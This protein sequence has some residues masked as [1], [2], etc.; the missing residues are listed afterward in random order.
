[1][2]PLNYLGKLLWVKIRWLKKGHSPCEKSLLMTNHVTAGYIITD[3]ERLRKPMELITE[4]F[5]KCMGVVKSAYIIE[6][7]PSKIES[8]TG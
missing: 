7:Q 6:I 2:K 4:Y 8:L 3:V 1:M 5:L